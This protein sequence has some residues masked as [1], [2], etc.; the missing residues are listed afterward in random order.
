MTNT[1]PHVYAAIRSVMTEVSKVGIAKNNR[2]VSQG[3]YFRGIDDVYNCISPALAKSGLVILPS[4]VD[5]IV[6]E[7]TNSKG[8]VVFFVT[9]TVDYTFVS[10][11]DGSRHVVRAYGEA[12]DSGDKATNKAMSAAYKYACFQTFCIPTEGDNDADATTHE[13]VADKKI[14]KEQAGIVRALLKEAKRDEEKFCDYF[15]ITALEELLVSDFD[16]AVDTL[17][18]MRP[19]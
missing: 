2:N 15:K 13:V 7:R 8:T 5:R 18:K 16:R 4:V 6:S 11:Q 1:V 9:L 12:S 19:A 17:Q 10:V 3:F 14:S